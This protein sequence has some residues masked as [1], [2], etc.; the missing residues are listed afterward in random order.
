MPSWT[1]AS[2]RPCGSRS[3][4][5]MCRERSSWWQGMRG[6]AAGADA[7]IPSASASWIFA[8]CGSCVATWSATSPRAPSGSCCLGM[9]GATREESDASELALLDRVAALTQA[10]EERHA[11][12]LDLQHSEPGLRVPR[13]IVSFNLGGAKIDL[14]PGVAN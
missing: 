8:A 5:S 11:E 6:S 13:V 14:G 10:G 12:V 4:R 1:L 7:N 2:A 3:I 9:A